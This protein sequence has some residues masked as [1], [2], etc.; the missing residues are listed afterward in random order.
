MKG[1]GGR[2]RYVKKYTDPITEGG[3]LYGNQGVT[4]DSCK[5]IAFSVRLQKPTTALRTLLPGDELRIRN[6]KGELQAVSA[7]GEL[8]G[9]IVSTKNAKIIECM[10]KGYSYKAVVNSISGSNCNVTVQIV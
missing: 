7:S 2:K 6:V 8:C 4:T 9:S 1:G 5:T 10:T 3:S